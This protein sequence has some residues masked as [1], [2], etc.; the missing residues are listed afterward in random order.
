MNFHMPAPPRVRGVAFGG[1]YSTSQS[2]AF[3]LGLRRAEHPNGR[4]RSMLF[5]I[6]HDE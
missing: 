5:C 1:G 2:A 3:A 6:L 4:D